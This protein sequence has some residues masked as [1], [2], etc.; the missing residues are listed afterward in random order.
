[1]GLRVLELSNH[2]AVIV[3]KRSAHLYIAVYIVSRIERAA[4][5]TGRLRGAPLLSALCNDCVCGLPWRKCMSSEHEIEMEESDVVDVEDN[6]TIHSV[7]TEL[8][9]IKSSQK[10]SHVNISLGRCQM[11]KRVCGEIATSVESVVRRIEGC[12][13]ERVPSEEIIWGCT[14]G[15]EQSEI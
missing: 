11:E 15:S 5:V 8:S 10:H 9:P 14:R 2:I 1:M 13:N 7:I 6:V 3:S 12:S 4:A